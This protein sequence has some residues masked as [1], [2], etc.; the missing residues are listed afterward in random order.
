MLILN[1]FERRELTSEY[2]ERINK[3]NETSSNRHLTSTKVKCVV[4]ELKNVE[5][6]GEYPPYQRPLLLLVCLKKKS[7]HSK[8]RSKNLL[9]GMKFRKLVI[10]FDQTLSHYTTAGYTTLEFSSA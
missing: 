9:L 10:N 6:M 1:Y 2:L 8:E 3:S 4:T 5:S 7:L